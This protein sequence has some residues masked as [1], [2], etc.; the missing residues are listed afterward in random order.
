MLT[1]RWPVMI[2]LLVLLSAMMANGFVSSPAPAQTG[3]AATPVDSIQ[4]ERSLCYG[5]C[6]A[7]RLHFDTSGRIRFLSLNPGDSGRTAQDSVSPEGLTFLERE[8]Q[9]F[10][11]FLLP[12]S[13]EGSVYC[14]DLATDHPTITVTIYRSSGVKQV[15]DYHGCYERSDHSVRPAIA[16]LRTFET[17]I[18]GVTASS[19][20]VRPARR[21]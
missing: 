17:M 7:Y 8:A 13:L 9:R 14:A 3:Q 2:T 21:R 4:L 6:P 5:T 11:F 18:D 1:V 20:W 10:G 16:R 19:R 12:D 15:R